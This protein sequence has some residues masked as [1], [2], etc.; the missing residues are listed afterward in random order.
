MAGGEQ[1]QVTGESV[2]NFTNEFYALAKRGGPNAVHGMFYAAMM[3]TMPLSDDDLARTVAE[4]RQ[5]IKMSTTR[6]RPN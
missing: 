5:R 2:T 1:D 3:L 6:G 4:A